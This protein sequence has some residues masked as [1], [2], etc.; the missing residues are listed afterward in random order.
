[1][2]LTL[3]NEK[4]KSTK[5]AQNRDPGRARS[6]HKKT[7]KKATMDL[8]SRISDVIGPTKVVNRPICLVAPRREKDQSH[9]ILSNNLARNFPGSY[10]C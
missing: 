9:K 2:A 7:S 1:M 4:R 8:L 6:N 10:S 5:L 3:F